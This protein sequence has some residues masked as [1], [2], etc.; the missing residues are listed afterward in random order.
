MRPSGIVIRSRNQFE[1]DADPAAHDLT[2]RNLELYDNGTAY[3]VQS[4]DGGSTGWVPDNPNI[5]VAF[6]PSV[7]A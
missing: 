6:A 2:Y 5:R 7:P 4:G 3:T 1:I